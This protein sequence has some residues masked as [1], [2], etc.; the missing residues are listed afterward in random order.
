MKHENKCKKKGK[1]VLPALE[2]K[3]LEK[4]NGGKRQKILIGALTESY[5]DRK[6]EKLFEKVSLKTSNQSFKKFS[7]RFSIDRKLGSID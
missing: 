7:T 5:R 3:N 6:V 1:R 4:K 2:E